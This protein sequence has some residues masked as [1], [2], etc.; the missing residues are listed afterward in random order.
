MLTKALLP[1]CELDRKWSETIVRRTSAINMVQATT[2]HSCYDCVLCLVTYF[3]NHE[4]Y[5]RQHINGD[6]Y[7][8]SLYGTYTKFVTS[9]QAAWQMF[10]SRLRADITRKSLEFSATL[11]AI[12]PCF[13]I[14]RV[15]VNAHVSGWSG[16][17]KTCCE[18][19]NGCA[20]ES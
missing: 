5:D 16:W 13:R 10:R 2:K 12:Q 11:W 18:H 4:R 8:E 6:L 17:L 1:T 7:H 3:V 20:D 15:N 9:I 19:H 14:K